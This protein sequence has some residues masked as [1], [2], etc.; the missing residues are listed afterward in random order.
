MNLEALF[1]AGFAGFMALVNFF[2]CRRFNRIREIFD[3]FVFNKLHTGVCV[4]DNMKHPT[5]FCQQILQLF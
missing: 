5:R 4:P 2:L 3:V 1:M